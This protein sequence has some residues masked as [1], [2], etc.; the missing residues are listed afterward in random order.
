MW[1]VCVGFLIAGL[2]ASRPAQFGLLCL[3]RTKGRLVRA[4][5][6][7]MMMMRMMMRM[8]MVAA[9]IPRVYSP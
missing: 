1:I 8:M 3:A 6:M 5:R 4:V 7:V 2:C 9:M